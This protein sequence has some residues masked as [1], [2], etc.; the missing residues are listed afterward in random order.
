MS[1]ILSTLQTV[2]IQ[3]MSALNRRKPEAVLCRIN[4]P[5]RLC[6]DPSA[7]VNVAIV[8]V[9]GVA[10]GPVDADVV[11]TA[12]LADLS[13]MANGVGDEESAEHL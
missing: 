12:G 10:V 11:Q 5:R 6:T 13:A 2:A 7:Q 8:A 3:R 4:H 1:Y 9:G